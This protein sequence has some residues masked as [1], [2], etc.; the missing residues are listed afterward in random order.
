MSEKEMTP[1]ERSELLLKIAVITEQD[2]I[3][4]FKDCEKQSEVFDTLKD[5]NTQLY[6][7]AL[8]YLATLDPNIVS[9]LLAHKLSAD[10][11]NLIMTDDD[12]LAFLE[13]KQIMVER[14]KEEK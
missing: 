14:K 5:M 1:T 3:L 9:N 10:I 8:N 11:G 13:S 6:K 2:M 12:F 4:H 7:F